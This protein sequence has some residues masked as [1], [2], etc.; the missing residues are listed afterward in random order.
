MN[1]DVIIAVVNKALAY[2]LLKSV[3]V[4]TL[5]PRRLIIVDNSSG[6]PFGFK[7]DKFDVS[8][9]KSKSG[10][11][12]ESWEIARSVLT[13]DSDYVSFLN[14]DIIIGDWFFQRVYETFQSYSSCG[15]A[16]PRTCQFIHEVRKGKVNYHQMKRRDACA[17]TIRK[18]L[19]DKIPP[20]PYKHLTTFHGDDWF[21]FHTRKLG[22]SWMLDLGNPI[23]HFVGV[24][25]L[26]LGLRRLK[27]KE[28]NAWLGIFKEEFG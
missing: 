19:L 23:Y 18:G 21:W 11:L 22:Y 27:A 3:E 26:K 7:T 4:N 13:K 15:V 1:I 16:C 24:S 9:Y 6:E 2:Q 17:F 20:V 25:I 12:N 8:L 28:R 10:R 5:L 14:D